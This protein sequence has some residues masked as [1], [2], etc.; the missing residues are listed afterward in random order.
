MNNLLCRVYQFGFRIAARFLKWRKPKLLSGSGSL[1]DLPEL[2][3]NE[4]KTK[5]LI[6]TDKGIMNSGLTKNLKAA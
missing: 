2:I 4:G 3:K 6:V 5:V 1:L